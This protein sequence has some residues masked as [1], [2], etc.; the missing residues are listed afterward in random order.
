MDALNKRAVL[1]IVF[2]VGLC[3][4]AER[5]LKGKQGVL[6]KSMEFEHIIDKVPRWVNESFQELPLPKLP[7]ATVDGTKLPASVIGPLKQLYPNEDF[8]VIKIHEDIPDYIERDSFTIG[9]DIHFKPGLYHPSHHVGQEVLGHEIAHVLQERF[10]KRRAAELKAKLETEE[11]RRRLGL[12]SL[13]LNITG[14]STLSNN[15]NVNSTKVNGT[16]F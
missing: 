14:N 8:D 10:A 2:C 12:I 11:A 3:H 9:N 16:K 7:N 6:I 4:G 5:S 15:T 13:P 1:L